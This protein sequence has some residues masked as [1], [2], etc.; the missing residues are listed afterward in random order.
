MAENKVVEAYQANNACR[1]K[2]FMKNPLADFAEQA[3]PEGMDQG[4]DYC[5]AYFYCFGGRTGYSLSYAGKQ[6]QPSEPKN[7]SVEEVIGSGATK[8]TVFSSNFRRN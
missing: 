3:K 6:E 2:R 5:F 7:L 8:G 4:K 1:C